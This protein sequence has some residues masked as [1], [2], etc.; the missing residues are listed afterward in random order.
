[1]EFLTKGGAVER[2]FDEQFLI[3]FAPRLRAAHGHTRMR[4][5]CTP[6]EGSDAYRQQLVVT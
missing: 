3:T 1:M 5:T 2:R 6:A 4:V